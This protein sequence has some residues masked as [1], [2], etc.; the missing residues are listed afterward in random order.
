MTS[1]RVHTL[2]WCSC[3]A[4]LRKDL[5]DNKDCADDNALY[6]SAENGVGDNGESFVDNHVGEQEGHQKEVTILADGLDLC[7]ILL[8]LTVAQGEWRLH[9]MT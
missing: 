3:I 9:R 4:G 1:K 8:L 2:I 7:S 5:H 6:A